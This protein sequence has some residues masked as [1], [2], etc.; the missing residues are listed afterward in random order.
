LGLTGKVYVYNYFTGTGTIVQ[1]G[2]SFT[3]TVG[4]G[5]YYIVVPIGQSGIS[6]LGD[7]GKFVS[8]GK[9]RISH[10]SDNGSVQATIAFANSET[11]LTMQGY[12]PTKPNVTAS[13][14]T[15]GSV[16]YNS[17]T[18]LFSFA[19]SPGSDKSATIT[20]VQT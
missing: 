4:T 15:T 5:S 16:T 18:G 2:H 13:D 6:F 20:I 3:G 9:K 19:V 17:A 12:S 11:S 10:L 14:G 1:A 8:L 7:A